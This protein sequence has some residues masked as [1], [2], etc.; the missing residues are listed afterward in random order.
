M[1]SDQG[2]LNDRS[3]NQLAYEGLKQAEKRLGINDNVLESHSSSD[4]DPDIGQLISQGDPVIVAIGFLMSDAVKAAAAK[5]PK[6]KFIMVDFPF[7]PPLPNVESL[8]FREQEAG[9][10]AGA[11]AGMVEHDGKLKG[12]NPQKIVSSVGGQKIPPVDRYIAGFEAGVKST[13]GEC[14][15]KH[16]YS[17]DFIA[18][19]K[20]K[21][22]ALTQ[23][24]AGSDI[25]FQ[26]AGQCGLGALDAAKSKGVWGIGVDADQSYLGPEV[27]TSATKHV[28]VAVFDAIKDAQAGSFQ[29]GDRT[30]GLAEGGVGLGTIAAPARIYA[31]RIAQIEA[32][33]RAGKITI[34]STV[35]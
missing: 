32:Q 6:T 25:V 12:L 17:Q 34:P 26:V 3:F 27:L 7:D 21:A 35:P 5:S 20:C 2:G 11:L 1:V 16:S 13:C 29:P 24:A 30:F 4:Y 14:T 19:D 23:I 31:P 8:I 18:Q 9:Y 28:D 22:Q 15:V 10:L 33:I